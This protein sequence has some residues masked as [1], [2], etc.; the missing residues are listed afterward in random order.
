MPLRKQQHISKIE[1]DREY[2]TKQ[3][4]TYIGNKRLLLSFI[5][6]AVESVKKELKADKLTMFDVFSGSGIASRFF[7][8]YAS[9]LYV[10]DL[11]AYCRLNNSCYLTN[12]SSVDMTLLSNTLAELKKRV[13]ENLRPGF[14]R[15]LYAPADEAKITKGE[16]VFYTIRNAM[17][18]DTARQEIENLPEELQRFYLAPLIYGASVHNNT[19]GI[20]KGF[21]KNSQGIGQYG[22]T[23]KNALA[24]ITGNIELQLPVFSKYECD[25]CIYQKDA[26]QAAEEMPEEVDIAYLDP[27]Y[28]QHPYGSNYFMLNLILDYK[29]P[30]TISKV[31]GIPNDW[32]H[33]AYNQRQ[34]AQKE[35]FKLVDS[36]NAKYILISYNSEGFVK[37]EDFVTYLSSLGELKTF[38]TKYHTFRGCRNLTERDIHVKEYLFLLKKR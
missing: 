4:I 21:Y 36:L 25:F 8:R 14:I 11:E 10:N 15:E 30:A 37:Y 26:R 12:A 22:G 13:E 24:R 29:R 16:R 31:A 28:N 20:F 2:L 3:I 17:Y 9:R 19:A 5:G 23:G 33:S 38:S 7:K 1:E 6:K 35:L 27:P 18:I 34:N 32:K